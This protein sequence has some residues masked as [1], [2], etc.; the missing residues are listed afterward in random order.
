[1]TIKI[2]DYIR[3]DID[4]EWLRSGWQGMEGVVTGFYQSWSDKQPLVQFK[5]TKEA[6]GGSS[7]RKVGD[8]V[9]DM[10][11]RQP[12]VKVLSSKFKLG[13]RVKYVDPMY[14]SS[15]NPI[16]YEIVDF[17]HAYDGLY[18]VRCAEIRN[19]SRTGLIH[20][21]GQKELAL[22]PKQPK[23]GDEVFLKDIKEGQTIR[24]SGTRH[25]IKIVREAVVGSISEY[26]IYSHDGSR[27]DHTG[28]QWKY[29]LVKE[30]PEK[31]PKKETLSKIANLPGH[32]VVYQS[33]NGHFVQALTKIGGEWSWLHVKPRNSG[34]EIVTNKEVAEALE[35]GAVILK[36][37]S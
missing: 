31:G 24:I 18:H 37:A 25:G 12:K 22:A 5:V 6:P 9:N 4:N 26:G 20:T 17:V 32:H 23:E 29:V 33:G 16:D 19:G 34:T 8:V 1:M 3:V 10:G 27:I 35:A 21:H 13:D 15:Y 11:L 36:P 2:G 28:V 30:A 14:F 7:S